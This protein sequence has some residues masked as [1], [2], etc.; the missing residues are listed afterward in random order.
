MGLDQPRG[1]SERLQQRLVVFALNA[2][3]A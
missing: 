3:S 2:S 1:L